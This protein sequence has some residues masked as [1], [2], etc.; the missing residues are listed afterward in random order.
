SKLTDLKCTS[1]VL[2]SVLQQLHLEANSRA[3]A[4]CVKCHN[5]I[6]AATDPS[7]AFEKFVSLFATLMTFSGN[8]DLD[9]LASDIFDT[10]SV[11]Q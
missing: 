4:F 5:D 9:A 8:V 7:E 10:P 2:L 6:L 3:W 11:L 1:V